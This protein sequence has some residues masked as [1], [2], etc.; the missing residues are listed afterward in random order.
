MN[1]NKIYQARCCGN[2]NYSIRSLGN[3]GYSPLIKCTFGLAPDEEPLA[4][5]E[6]TDCCDNFMRRYA[7]PRDKTDAIRIIRD[8]IKRLRNVDSMTNVFIH[9]KAKKELKYCADIINEN[10]KVIIGENE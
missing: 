2:C 9:P 5:L 4:G 1:K 3:V 6:I 8:E 10:L 7:P